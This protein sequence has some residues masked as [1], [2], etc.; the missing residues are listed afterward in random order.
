[1]ESFEH[2]DKIRVVLPQKYDLVTGDTFQLFYRGVVE[3]PDPFCYDI[4][5]VCEKG[6]NF[7]RYFEF[8]PEEPGE[9]KLTIYVYGPDRT[10]LGQGQTLLKVAQPVSPARQLN[11]LCFGASMVA[12]GQWASEAYR[13]LTA[14]DGQPAGLGLE[15]ISF[16]GTK[17]KNGAGYEGYGGW[18]WDSYFSTRVDDFWVICEGHDKDETD[19]H[20]LWLDEK[21]N[22]W[23]LETIVPGYLK[24]V[25]EGGHKSD[26]PSVGKLQH[27]ANAVHKENVEIDRSFP[28]NI[29]PFMDPE[30]QVIDFRSY[31]ERHGFGAIGAVYVLL[32]WNGLGNVKVPWREHCQKIVADAKQVIDL[33]HRDYPQAQ[34]RILG[35]PVPSV[36]G[37]TGANYGARLPYCDDYGLTRYVMD[38]NLAYEAWALEPEYC[39][40]M[41][42]INVSGQF[43]TDYNMPSA[44]KPVNTRNKRKER[45]DTN[46]V[47]PAE[48]GYMQIA[49]AVFRNMV[50]LCGKI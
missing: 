7:P 33:L 26:M 24:F 31:C 27:Y 6:K 41:E 23:K 20:S 8:L 36:R 39:E 50:H 47:H 46:G 45:V 14:E 18:R 35:L 4:L 11:V 9:H 21:G 44:D 19:Q 32:G 28:E 48:E 40:F 43:D 22:L 30:R 2:M 38:L 25:R 3:A 10:L 16:I 5:A 42:F 13:R 29:S 15:N 12:G 49:D 34:V 37:G 1:M 17:E